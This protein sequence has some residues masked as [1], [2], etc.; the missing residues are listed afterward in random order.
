[1]SFKKDYFDRKL[2]HSVVV[3]NYLNR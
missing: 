3:Q 2:Y 1:M